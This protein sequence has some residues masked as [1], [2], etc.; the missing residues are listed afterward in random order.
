MAPGSSCSPVSGEGAS[1][2]M[3]LVKFVSFLKAQVRKS[4]K[5]CSAEMDWL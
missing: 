1:E 3:V 4:L 2:A 5:V